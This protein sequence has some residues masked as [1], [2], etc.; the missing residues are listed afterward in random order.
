MD[1][2]I[3]LFGNVDYHQNPTRLRL[4]DADLSGSFIPDGGVT[5]PLPR[6][7]VWNDCHGFWFGI[8][9]VSFRYRRSNSFLTS[10]SVAWVSVGTYYAASQ[11]LQWRLPLALACVGPMGLLLGLLFVLGQRLSP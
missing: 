5:T 2:W 10:R 8:R 9:G 3:P 6:S 4:G 1:G 7:H 11:T